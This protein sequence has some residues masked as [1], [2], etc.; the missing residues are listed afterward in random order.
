VVTTGT[1]QNLKKAKQVYVSFADDNRVPARI[2]GYDPNADV[3]LIKIDPAG[4][5]L[6]PLPLGSSSQLRVGA[7]VAAIGSPFGE[8][9]SLSV[10]VISALNRNIESLT[11]FGIGHA[12]QTDA[13]IN[14]GNSGGPLIDSRGRVIGINAQ[15]KTESGEG[16]GVGFAVPVDII[17]R[18][19]HDLRA[20]GR[21]A[22]GYLGVSSQSL[23]PQLARRLGIGAPRGALIV[24]VQDGSP[25]DHAGLS[26]GSGKIGFQGQ[27]DVPRGGDAIV[28][29]DGRP[30]SGSDDLADV[31]AL[32]RPGD[33]VVLRVVRGRSFRTVRVKLA[34]RPNKAPK[35]A[36]QP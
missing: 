25:A 4:L 5:R 16:S 35:D 6:T 30:V 36:R 9:Q 15:I 24:N 34:P 27:Q 20:S 3:A 17:K 1:G 10:G 33:T 23:Y 18:S 19:L 26:S 21:V 29:V 31:I 14:K 2:V 8:E 13:A 28:A 12:I 7:P 11:A 32:K 22:Y